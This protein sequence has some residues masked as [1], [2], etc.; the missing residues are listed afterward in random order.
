MNIESEFVE[1]DFSPLSAIKENLRAKL[2]NERRRKIELFEEDLDFLAAAG[3][4]HK[5]ID[6]SKN[7]NEL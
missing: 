5:K 4:K 7:S 6:K 1:I 2:L 3:N